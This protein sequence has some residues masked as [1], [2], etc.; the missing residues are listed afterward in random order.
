MKF[1]YYI[2]DQKFELK[3]GY[4]DTGYVDDYYDDCKYNT[5]IYSKESHAID[6]INN[7]NV[8]DNIETAKHILRGMIKIQMNKNTKEIEKLTKYNQE[9]A[10]K[11][12]N[13]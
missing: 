13:V 4:I 12:F 10:E 11:L 8:F 6:V 2:D 7:S 1:V 3:E 9:L 5:V